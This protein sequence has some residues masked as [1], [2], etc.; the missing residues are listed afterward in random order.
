MVKEKL[1]LK[2]NK[3]II[4]TIKLELCTM[5]KMKGI[6][7]I[8]LIAYLIIVFMFFSSF[9]VLMTDMNKS[10]FFFFQ[11]TAI[12]LL[13]LVGF[14]PIMVGSKMLWDDIYTDMLQ[15][16][17]S[18]YGRNLV[19][20][21]K[22]I[23][24]IF[25]QFVFSF[26][27][28]MIA[29]IYD[30]HYRN[31]GDTISII[32]IFIIIQFFYNIWGFISMAITYLCKS[33][34]FATGI[35]VCIYYLE[36]Y[37]AQYIPVNII[38]WFPMWNQKSILYQFFSKPEGMIA[39]IQK[40]YNSEKDAYIIILGLFFILFFSFILQFLKKDIKEKS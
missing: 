37:F 40:E 35:L 24:S 15:V 28:C 34:F 8:V 33:S 14:V 23:S 30:W 18:I 29:L 39:I 19:L 27:P 7:W 38:K 3:D 13:S 12:C 5:K 4:E 36:A 11:Q 21:S 20:L 32:K 26:I 25:F 9:Q 22:I 2:V 17:T 16:K 6:F 1:L 31:K 10:A